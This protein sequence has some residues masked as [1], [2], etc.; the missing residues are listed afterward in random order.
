MDRP[1]KARPK[2]GINVGESLLFIV[3]L[4]LAGYI[5]FRSPLFQVRRLEVT[6][7]RLLQPAQ[8]RKLAGINPGENIFAVNLGQAQKKIALLPLVKTAVLRRILP[9][10]VL[11]EVTERTPVALLQ[12]GSVFAEVDRDGYYL[13]QG[14]VDITG[15]PL[16]T[17]IRAVLPAPGRKVDAP[18]L[19]PVLQFV[20][21]LPPGLAPMLSEV[22]VESDGQLVLTTL[23]GVPVLVGDATD[24][25]GKGEL[26]LAILQQLGRKRPIAYIDLASVKSPVIKYQN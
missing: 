10:T 5:L 20:A 13:Q 21:G 24:P 25:A 4:V 2:P 12:E 7:T 11:I 15:L 16:L 8:I 9:S 17:G 26:L 19:A 23:Y 1:G 3:L 22:H 18:G 14:N 6:G